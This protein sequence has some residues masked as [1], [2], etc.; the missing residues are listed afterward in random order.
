[1]LTG[2]TLRCRYRIYDRLGSGGAA[3][4]YLARDAQT[5]QMVIVKVVHPHLVD[6]QFMGRFRREIELLQQLNNPYIIRL[7]DW[8]L[9]EFEAE[10]QQTLSYIIAE[11]VEGHTLAD[12]V[13]TRGA[14]SEPDALA[15]A[16]QLALGLV[17]IHNHGI[18][19][20]DVKAQNIMITP[21]NQ[22]KLIDF[23]IAKG[24]NH[25][26]LT[27]PSHFAGTLY[28]APPEQILEAHGVDHRA[29]IYALGI[30]L[31]EMLM[32]SLPIKSREFGTV[33][34]KI[35]SGD[36]DPLTGVSPEVESL[37]SDM[38]AYRVENR[39]ATAGEV[40]RRIEKI[41]GGIQDPSL[42]DLPPSTTA[43]L[44]RVPS[45]ATKPPS[46]PSCKLVTMTG[47]SIPL[48]R[49]DM[50]I[51]RSHPRD[52]ATPDIDLWTLGIEDARTASRRHCR[53]F[54]N[55]ADYF[56][57]DLGSMN[58]TFLNDQQIQA[59]DTHPLKEGDRVTAGRVQL[60]FSCS[61][62]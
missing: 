38:I 61:D 25:A 29:D 23:G 30:V 12:I 45:E 43:M 5:G 62:D 51:G 33:A 59:G 52:S 42:S 40:V 14:L 28:Y 48:T 3:T 50:V 9:R 21:D 6:D 26:T 46:G 34:S 54:Q 22:A 39:I 2:H 20:R 58:G 7:Y 57:E 56:I 27:D 11:F 31:Y 49:P 32:A 17:D 35:I 47:L 41:L 15:I 8:A 55:G 37:V 10:T 44:M 19:H 13:D 18:V 4:V 24:Q 36:L 1:M 16:R 60:T 53:I